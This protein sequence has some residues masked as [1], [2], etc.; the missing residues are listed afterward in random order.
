MAPSTARARRLFSVR[1]QGIS[2]AGARSH[3]TAAAPAETAFAMKSCPST[4]KPVMAT[5]RSPGRVVR[6]S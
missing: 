2:S 4:A 6:E 1:T 5:N 3:S